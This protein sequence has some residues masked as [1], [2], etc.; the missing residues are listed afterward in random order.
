MN[1]LHWIKTQDI[2]AF[3][4]I[5]YKL[6]Y[7]LWTI[8][9]SQR[10]SGAEL[11]TENPPSQVLKLPLSTEITRLQSCQHISRMKQATMALLYGFKEHYWYISQSGG[12][13]EL[14]LSSYKCQK[15]CSLKS[16]RYVKK[17]QK[18]ASISS[19]NHLTWWVFASSQRLSEWMIW[20]ITEI[21]LTGISI[22]IQPWAAH[23]L[24]WAWWKCV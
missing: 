9:N 1:C 5:F 17:S 12:F 10:I 23:L 2:C 14:L 24:N 7:S 20:N 21:V 3:R 11:R 22:S 4:T 13:I 18:K 8:L 15:Q 19:P 16:T 6:H